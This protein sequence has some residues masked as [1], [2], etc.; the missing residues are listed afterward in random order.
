[1]TSATCFSSF[2][3]LSLGA[4]AGV[5]VAPDFGPDP[6]CGD[7]FV[8]GVIFILFLKILEM[9]IWLAPQP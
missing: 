2:K 7:L 3:N 6:F 8:A 9:E 4:G 5:I 1:M